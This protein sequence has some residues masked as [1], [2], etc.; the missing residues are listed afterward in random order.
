MTRRA[1]T[2]S[3]STLEKHIEEIVRRVIREE[4][5]ERKTADDFLTVKE[6]AVVL[7]VSQKTVRRWIDDGSL[8]SY[9]EGRLIRVKRSEAERRLLPR[10]AKAPPELSPEELAERMF[11]DNTRR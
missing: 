2:Y 4:L 8:P 10:G 1:R 7:D 9:G 3:V 11:G 5:G 6:A